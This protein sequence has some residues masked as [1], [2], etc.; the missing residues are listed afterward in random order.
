MA[1]L[2]LVSFRYV[3]YSVAVAREKKIMLYSACE[4]NAEWAG[5][6]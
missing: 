6:I 2:V 5:A 4:L 3:V 1:F